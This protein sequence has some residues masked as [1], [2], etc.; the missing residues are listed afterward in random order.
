MRYCAD[1]RIHQLVVG[2]VREGWTYRR[3]K[4]HPRV[5][6]PSG[7]FVTFSWTPSCHFAVD[8]ILSDVKRIKSG[9]V[10]KQKT[11]A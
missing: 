7:A 9:E 5:T 1:K 2:L 4:T 3:G 8:K 11:P 6:S 10:T